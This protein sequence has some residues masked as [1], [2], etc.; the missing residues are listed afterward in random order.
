M[1]VHLHFADVVCFP[2]RRSRVAGL[3]V[4]RMKVFMSTA[5]LKLTNS[6]YLLSRALLMSPGARSTSDPH[7]ART[8]PSPG[9]AAAPSRAPRSPW[10]TPGTRPCLVSQSTPLA[11]ARS[12]GT[13]PSTSTVNEANAPCDLSCRPD[14]DHLRH[15]LFRI[16]DTSSASL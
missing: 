13:P 2:S 4:W 11:P 16:A 15:R 1:H 5:V 14:H 3:V 7:S 12:A 6:F 9:R 10:R 8:D